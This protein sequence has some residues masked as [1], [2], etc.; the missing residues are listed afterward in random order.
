MNTSRPSAS[1]K[2]RPIQDLSTGEHDAYRTKKKLPE[3]TCCPDCGAVFAD[4]RWQWLTAVEGIARERCPACLRIQDHF[5]AGYVSLT[6]SYINQH[7]AEILSIVNNLESKEK[8]EHPLQRV[9]NIQ[10]DSSGMQITTT[11][12]HLAR[13]IG[14]ALRHAHGGHL[15]IKYGPDDHVVRVAWNR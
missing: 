9:M 14:D 13:A 6:G 2:T 5:P 8:A 3:G 11:D 4:G 15:E 12:I 7:R 1:H 10:E